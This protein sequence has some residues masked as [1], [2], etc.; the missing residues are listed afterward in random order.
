MTRYSRHAMPLI[1]RLRL[2]HLYRAGVGPL[3]GWLR[4]REY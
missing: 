4:R 3:A 2:P 1:S